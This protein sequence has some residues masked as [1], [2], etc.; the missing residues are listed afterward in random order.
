MPIEKSLNFVQGKYNVLALLSY[1]GSLT[2]H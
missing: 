2:Q 1:S